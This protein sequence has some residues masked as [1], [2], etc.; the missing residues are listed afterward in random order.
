MRGEHAAAIA[1]FERLHAEL[2]KRD[3]A[4]AWP[5]FRAS[6]AFASALNAVGDHARAKRYAQREPAARRRQD[7]ERVVVHYLEPQ[8][9]LALAEAGLGNHDEAVRM[10]DGLLSAHGHQDQPLLIGLLHKARAE[11][12]LA[13]NDQPAFARH[14]AEMSAHLPRDQESRR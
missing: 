8:R 6:F 14:F 7:V 2:A 10:L 13:M 4:L 1:A 5:A 3:P 12:A 11:V 9:Q